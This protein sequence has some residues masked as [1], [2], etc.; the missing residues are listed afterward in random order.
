MEDR[1]A[2]P[3]AYPGAHPQSYTTVATVSAVDSDNSPIIEIGDALTIE[4]SKMLDCRN[5]EPGAWVVVRNPGIRQ[6]NYRVRQYWTTAEGA[7]LVAGN[8]AIP[9]HRVTAED[10]IDG[11][12]VD[13]R[14]SGPQQISAH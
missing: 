9:P 11:I 6:G 5:I 8:P 2:Y 12:V 13:I 4:T 10:A 1:Q 14:K 3:G 7:L